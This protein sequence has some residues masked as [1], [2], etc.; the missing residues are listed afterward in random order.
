MTPACIFAQNHKTNGIIKRMCLPL[1][2]LYKKMRYIKNDAKKYE[3]ICGRADQ[4]LN[5]RKKKKN[6]KRRGTKKD[7]A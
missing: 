4:S 6:E 1:F 5:V 7:V 3:N 2:F